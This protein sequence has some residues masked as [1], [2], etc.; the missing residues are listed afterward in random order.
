MPLES[1]SLRQT[2]SR[3]SITEGGP[4]WDVFLK[5]VTYQPTLSKF[6]G[7]PVKKIT[8]YFRVDP[9][10]LGNRIPRFFQNLSDLHVRC[11]RK[12]IYIKFLSQIFLG[13]RSVRSRSFPRM[14]ASDSLSQTFGMDFFIPFPFPKFGNGFFYFLP[15]PEFRE[16]VFSIPFPFPN[17]QKA[18]PLTPALGSI[19]PVFFSIFLELATLERQSTPMI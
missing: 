8:L 12:K 4:V 13:V 6:R 11:H 2:L 17:P 14:E 3:F 9:Y 5:S 10:T 7:G 18:F 16:C 15:V 1:Y 19:L